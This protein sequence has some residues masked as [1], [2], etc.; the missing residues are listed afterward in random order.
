MK[1]S[2]IFRSI[3]I[4]TKQARDVYT[5]RAGAAALRAT[6]KI[7]GFDKLLEE[8]DILQDSTLSIHLVSKS[9]FELMVFKKSDI[10]LLVFTNVDITKILGV[11]IIQK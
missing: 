1:S 9:E 6:K 4:S 5:T 10:K 2:P 11:L 7:R 3:T 8:L